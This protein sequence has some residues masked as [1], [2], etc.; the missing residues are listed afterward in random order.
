MFSTQQVLRAASALHSTTRRCTVLLF[1][2]R[3]P[4]F[5]TSRSRLAALTRAIYPLRTFPPRLV[6]WSYPS[7]RIAFQ[8]RAR[9]SPIALSC[10]SLLSSIHLI[11]QHHS[12]TSPFAPW[13]HPTGFLKCPIINCSQR[14]AWMLD[15]IDN[16]L[17]LIDC[18]E[19]TQQ[20]HVGDRSHV[21]VFTCF[22]EIHR[23]HCRNRGM[24]GQTDLGNALRHMFFESEFFG[25]LL[26]GIHSDFTESFSRPRLY[27][28]RRRAGHER[29]EVTQPLA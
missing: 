19:V 21:V 9:F 2:S 23:G 6:S 29:R 7:L 11:F 25:V 8:E 5:Q 3:R 10:Y 17:G 28:D 24:E 4:L 12:S 20:F 15:M 18:F 13:V 26:N 16:Y 22:L 1:L 14:C 27:P